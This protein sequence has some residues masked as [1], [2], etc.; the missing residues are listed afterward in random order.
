MRTFAAFAI[1]YA[2]LVGCTSPNVT[3]EVGTFAEAVQDVSKDYRNALAIDGG[4]I[5]EGQIEALV[6]DRRQ[7]LQ[8]SVGCDQVGTN[9]PA[10]SITDCSLDD[11]GVTLPENSVA[12]AETQLLLLADYFAAL[13]TLVKSTGPTDIQNGTATA[14]AA[15]GELDKVLPK[16]GLGAFAKTLQERRSGI[17]NLAGFA[18]EQYKMRQ[19]R[20]VV[21]EA[22][23]AVRRLVLA[24]KD[25]AVAA[26]VERPVDAYDRLVEKQNAMDDLAQSNDPAAYRAAIQAFLAEYDAFVV[27]RKTGLVPRLDLIAATHAALKDRLTGSATLPEIATLIDRLNS[28]KT[29][30]DQE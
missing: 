3:A 5:R 20:K 9:D 4:T 16:P 7:L 8:L 26:G 11:S 19:L 23:P 27:Y 6:A 29:D 28:L 25:S 13:D 12:R 15:V 14:L 30:F 18:A 10:A 2:V 17:A 21:T 22:D 1:P 24:L